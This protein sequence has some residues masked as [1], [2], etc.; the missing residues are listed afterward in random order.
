[1]L[2]RLTPL[3]YLTPSMGLPVMIWCFL[4]LTSDV[5]KWTSLHTHGVA[6]PSGVDAFAWR[7]MC[8]SLQEASVGLC[9]ALA[10]VACCLS[11]SLVDDPAVLMPF[12]ACR[13]IPLDKHPGVHPIGIG[14]V[15]RQIVAKAILHVLG[16]DIVSAAGPLQTCAG[17]AAGSEATVHAMREM[18]KDS[19]VKLLSLL[20]L[21]MHLT[22]LITKQHCITS[23]CF[24]H[25]IYYPAEYLWC[26][27]P[28]VCCW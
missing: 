10:S 14:D 15:P 22:V 11:T 16:E 25:L 21:Q 13:L 7:R 2:N 18:F 8:T 23:Q 1:M 19:S 24:V 20:M 17:H 3:Y 26:S 27:C 6:G 5:V 4:S 28:F 12:V 9:E